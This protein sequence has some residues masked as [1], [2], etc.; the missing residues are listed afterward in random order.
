MDDLFYAIVGKNTNSN[1]G[2]ARILAF[3][4]AFVVIGGVFFWAIG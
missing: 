4:L 3:I 1:E 2:M